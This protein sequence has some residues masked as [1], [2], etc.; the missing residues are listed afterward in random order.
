LA[1]ALNQLAWLLA[2]DSDLLQW[3]GFRPCPRATQQD[4]W[5]AIILIFRCIWQH[6]N[7]AV[8]NEARPVVEAIEARIRE[9]YNIWPLARLF[10]SDSFEP[11]P[12]IPGE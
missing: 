12:W 10:R 3:L 5:T 4:L 1:W 9:E 2:A 6:R 7:N 11:V 8:F